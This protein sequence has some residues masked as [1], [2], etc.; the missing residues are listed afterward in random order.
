VWAKWLKFAP[1]CPMHSPNNQKK[2]KKKSLVKWA[3]SNLLFGSIF[4]DISVHEKKKEIFFKNYRRA[5]D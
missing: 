5:C 3:A 1:Y 2:K 4:I